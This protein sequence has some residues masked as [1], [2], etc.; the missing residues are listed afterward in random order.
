MSRNELQPHN[1]VNGMNEYDRLYTAYSGKIRNLLERFDVVITELR[2]ERDGLDN[3][4]KNMGNDYRNGKFLLAL[5]IGLLVINLMIVISFGKPTVGNVGGIF[6]IGFAPLLVIFYLCLK[7]YLNAKKSYENFMD[8]NY[9]AKEEDGVINNYYFK[10]QRYTK[11]IEILKKRKK[12]YESILEK[13]SVRDA[14]SEK[15]I[16]DL[17]HVSS[18]VFNVP[19][20]GFTY[21]EL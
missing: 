16:D 4:K 11:C 1:H 18:I 12:Y 5:G 3:Y 13:L 20:Y 6:A 15:E 14:I 10:S 2:C 19:E 17:E 21:H 9:K 8:I 7:Y